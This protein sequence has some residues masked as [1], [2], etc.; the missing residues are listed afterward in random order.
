MPWTCKICGRIYKHRNATKREVLNAWWKHMKRFHPK[1]YREKKKKATRKMLR[2]K[3]VGSTTKRKKKRKGKKW[4][5]IGAP[6]SAK[7]KRHLARIR[8]KR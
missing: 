4:G 8:K 1:K 5:K 2:T 7:R 3:G 6:H